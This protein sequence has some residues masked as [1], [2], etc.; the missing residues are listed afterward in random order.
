MLEGDPIPRLP[1]KHLLGDGDIDQSILSVASGLYQPKANLL[2]KV[3][4]GQHL[5]SIQNFFGQIIGKI[6]AN[7][8]GIVIM[9]WRI[10]HVRIDDE[11]I[12]ITGYLKMP[13]C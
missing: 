2:E 8:D 11:L 3:I 6:T 13:S 10:T 4:T 5:G 9:Q 12:Y 7:R 1:A